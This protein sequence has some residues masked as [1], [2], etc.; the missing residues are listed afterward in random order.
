LLLAFARAKVNDS[1]LV[2]AGD[3]PLKPALEEEAARL[4][5]LERVRFLGFVNQSS[6]PA[7]Y[8]AADLLIL[9]SEHEPF[10]VVVNEAM[11]CGCAVAV[12]DRVGA[13][14]DLVRP[15]ENGFVF[16]CGEI[17]ELAGILREALA[18]RPRLR[19]MGAAARERM[20]DWSPAQNIEAFLSAMEK[21]VSRKGA[22]HD[23]PVARRGHSE[24]KRA[25]KL[26][27]YS[28]FFTPSIGGVEAIIESLAGGLSELRRPDGDKEFDILLVT[29][30]S[31]ENSQ[32]DRR[33]GFQVVRRPGLLGL[34]RLVGQAQTVLVA[35]PAMLP[36][37]LALLRRKRLLVGHHG[38]QAVCPNGLLFHHPTQRPCVGHFRAGRY[39]ECLR[40][41]AFI[42][43]RRKSISLLLLTFPRRALCQIAALNLP[44][45]RHVAN[46][47]D[48][49]RCRVTPNGVA[50]TYFSGGAL[51]GLTPEGDAVS[52]AYIGRLVVEKG[53]HVLIEAAG[54][55]KGRRRRFHVD[56]L[57]DGPERSRLQEM[58]GKLNLRGEVS[59]HGFRRGAELEDVMKNAQVTVIPSIWEDVAPLAALEHMMH[60]RMIVASDIG[61]LAELVGET[62]LKFAPGDAE[63]LAERI[64]QVLQKPELIRELGKLARERA[65]AEYALPRTIERYRELL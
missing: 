6:L 17:E 53:V 55:L 13:R 27:I 32:E 49:P 23:T 30:T 7:V 51:R 20:R 36:M 48:L 12:S 37:I 2:F 40:C 31:T 35:G 47:I 63:G 65:L 33:L 45:S 16:R 43:N 62:A 28:H 52:I 60:G 29:Q 50:D 41:N 3:G 54:I 26:L 57:G 21:A 14:F 9:P 1:Y 34:W 64:E 15:G 25:V 58:A 5:I 46:R 42:E 61:G 38:Y 4:G 56:I 18:D 59:F 24:S 10:A 39:L 8:S 11:L 22:R 44:V 19:Q